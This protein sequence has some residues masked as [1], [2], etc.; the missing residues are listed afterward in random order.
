MEW[1]LKDEDLLSRIAA[2]SAPP[3]DLQAILSD[4]LW[5]NAFS[6]WATDLGFNQG[7]YNVGNL[8]HVWRDLSYGAPG[9]TVYAQYV[10]PSGPSALQWPSNVV[11]RFERVANGMDS[12]YSGALAELR[13]ATIETL[14]PYA[15]QFR[16][17]IHSLQSQHVSEPTLVDVKLSPPDLGMVDGIN[18][19]EL[20]DLPEFGKDAA[21]SKVKV[22]ANTEVVLIGDNHPGSAYEYLNA[23]GH[24][25]GTIVMMKRGGAFSAGRVEVGLLEIINP[26]GQSYGDLPAPSQ[27]D[28]RQAVTEAI[29]RVSNKEVRHNK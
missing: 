29:G 28:I 12:D 4:E 15:S 25:V 16:D 27:D 26:G 22:Y 11:E 6:M 10:D 21:G 13:Y 19:M 5:A 7:D 9:E 1:D 3:S 2:T 14:E 20:K 23:T 17:D 8:Y 18:Q 24:T